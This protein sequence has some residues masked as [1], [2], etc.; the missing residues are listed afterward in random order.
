MIIINFFGGPGTGKSTT[1]AGLFH[2][3][4]LEGV[5]VE[6]VTEYAKDLTW[7]KRF[8]ALKDQL[9]V[10]SKQ[11]GRLSRLVDKVDFV[12][13][14]GPLINSLVYSPD[15]YF[16]SFEPLATE[17]FN[18]Y[19]NYNILLERVKKYSP[20]G[21]SQDE[22]GAREIDLLSEQMLTRKLIPFNR[23]PADKEAPKTIFDMIKNKFDI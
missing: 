9:Y 15:N 7:D 22:A 21:R 13:T 17:I 14:D 11:H 4:K 5:N 3:M 10:F 6:L 18:H 2:L 1:A 16:A 19:S 20:V 8:A 23:V 12:V